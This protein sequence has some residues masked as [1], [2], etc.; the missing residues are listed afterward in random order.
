MNLVAEG[1]IV[2]TWSSCICSNFTDVV[3]F[4][5]VALSGLLNRR[6]AEHFGVHVRVCLD[7]VYSV[8]KVDV[9]YP[10]R[11]GKTGGNEMVIGVH[12]SQ[13]F[14]H[15]L[16]PS[17]HW[18]GCKSGNEINLIPKL[19]RIDGGVGGITTDEVTQF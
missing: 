14:C 1:I 5:P 18:L 9:L 11:I 7:E 8:E 6:L 3:W 19:P 10:C 2:G 13:L 17:F 15:L 16:V 4:T 12:R